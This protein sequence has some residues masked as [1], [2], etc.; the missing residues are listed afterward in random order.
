[1][2]GVLNKTNVKTAI[3]V[4]VVLF[5]ITLLGKSI[6]AVASLKGNLGLS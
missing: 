2:T 1:M 3:V 5:A 6:P 4:V